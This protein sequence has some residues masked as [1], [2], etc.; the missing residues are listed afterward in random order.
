MKKYIHHLKFAQVADC[1]ITDSPDE[2]RRGYSLYAEIEADNLPVILAHLQR[3]YRYN[4]DGENVGTS[5]Y[6]FV[7]S[8]RGLADDEAT[9]REPFRLMRYCSNGRTEMNYRVFESEDSVE[10]KYIVVSWKETEKDI[11]TFLNVEDHRPMIAEDIFS[12]FKCEDCEKIIS[13]L[14]SVEASFLKQFVISPNEYIEFPG[15]V[16][17]WLRSCIR[18]I[19]TKTGLRG[20]E[21][22]TR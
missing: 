7:D 17:A 11:R 18:H 16:T 22:F 3:V 4:I 12:V 15:T 21:V 19:K 13:N 6:D 1:I 10:G 9:L 20:V 2:T 5:A 8:V 14:Y